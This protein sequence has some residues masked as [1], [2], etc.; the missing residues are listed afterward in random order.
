MY[1]FKFLCYGKSDGLFRVMT[2]QFSAVKAV[3]L[4][5]HADIWS[6]DA[7]LLTTMTIVN[8]GVACLAIPL[9]CLLSVL[10][11]FPGV[12]DTRI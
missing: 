12:F 1:Q 11:G 5:A 3:C 8:W 6:K 7:V 10:V 4:S 9:S 2:A